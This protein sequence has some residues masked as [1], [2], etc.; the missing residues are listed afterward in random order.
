MIAIVLRSPI[1]DELNSAA[2]GN[3]PDYSWPS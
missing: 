1:A 2:P 3:L